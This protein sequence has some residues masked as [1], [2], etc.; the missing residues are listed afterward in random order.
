MVEDGV[1][2]SVGGEDV[3][4]EWAVVGQPVVGEFFR[5]EDE[6]GLVAQLVVFDDGEGGEGFAE[7]DAIG[8]D[9]AV[10]GFQLVDQ[11]DGGIALEVEELFPNGSVLVAGAVIGK[12]VLI[13][14]LKELA[15]NVVEHHEI[16]AFRGVLRIDVG[17]MLDDLVGDGDHAR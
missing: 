2:E 1:V 8:E 3:G 9:A 6:D 12:D 15:E 14:V 4:L 11:A 10:V 5:A 13:D 7:A 16:D 17:D